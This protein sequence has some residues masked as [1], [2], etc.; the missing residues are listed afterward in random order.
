MGRF[1]GQKQKCGFSQLSASEYRI[2]K[3]LANLPSG[4]VMLCGGSVNPSGSSGTWG[5]H[6]EAGPSWVG[7]TLWGHDTAVPVRP[8]RVGFLGSMCV[9]RK[10]D[11]V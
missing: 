9:Q 4:A 5:S 2:S 1:L 3:A 11:T 8:S 10:Y 7:A 6:G